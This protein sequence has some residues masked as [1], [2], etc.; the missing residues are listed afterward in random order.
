MFLSARVMHTENST[1][2]SCHTSSLSAVSS[3]YLADMK[4]EEID[5]V[6]YYS[7]QVDSLMDDGIGNVCSKK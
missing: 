5:K 1:L 4:E 7:M 6:K 2:Q 3:P